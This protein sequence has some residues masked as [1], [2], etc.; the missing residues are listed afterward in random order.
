MA[1]QTQSERQ[2]AGKKAAATRKRNASR[3]SASSTRRS[4]TT[5]RSSARSTARGARTTAR[6]AATTSATR[7]KA[8]AK[9]L[10]AAYLQAERAVLIPVGAA[11]TA[12]DNV[13][14]NVK[15]FTSRTGAEREDR[16]STRLN[17]SHRT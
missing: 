11:L 6:S 16:K 15:P 7:A 17:S 12:R 8:E 2:A 4:A 13:L 9:G 10:Q 1:T 5:T 14:E 3:R